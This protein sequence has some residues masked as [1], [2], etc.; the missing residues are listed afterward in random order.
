MDGRKDRWTN[1]TN[2]TVAF[3][4]SKNAP[5]SALYSR[6]TPVKY[7]AMPTTNPKVLVHIFLEVLQKSIN[8][9]IIIIINILLLF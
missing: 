9:F 6:V 4:S 8:G 7:E 1:I 2:L 3:P 5:S